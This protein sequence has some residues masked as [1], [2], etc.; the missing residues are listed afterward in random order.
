MNIRLAKP[1]DMPAVFELAER[2][3]RESRYNRYP[4]RPEKFQN[5]ADLAEAEPDSV[6]C[7]V[8]EETGIIGMLCAIVTEHYFADMVY[9]TNLALYVDPDSRGKLV[10]PKMIRGFERAARVRGVDEIMLG[11]TFGV[12]S[13]RTLRLFNALGYETIGGLTVKYIGD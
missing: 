10:A 3:Y 1:D 9:A 5:L 13:D 4:L 8:A 7:V 12:E 6:L 11:A 2:G